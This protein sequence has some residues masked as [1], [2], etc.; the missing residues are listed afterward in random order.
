L[1]DDNGSL[2]EIE[3]DCGLDGGSETHQMS[4]VAQ[5]QASGRNGIL[6]RS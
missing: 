4:G 3:H 5:D 2:T 6:R 1:I